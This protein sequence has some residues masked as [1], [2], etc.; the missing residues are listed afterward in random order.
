MV[1][2]VVWQDWELSMD[3]PVFMPAYLSFSK[4]KRY[5]VCVCVRACL[6]MALMVMVAGLNADMLH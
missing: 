4:G 5:P 2:H 6:L 3:L 1:S